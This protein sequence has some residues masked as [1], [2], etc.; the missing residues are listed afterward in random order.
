[1]ANPISPKLADTV[2]HVTDEHK[3]EKLLQ[4]LNTLFEKSMANLQIMT[5]EGAVRVFLNIKPGEQINK[6]LIPNKI[7]F[8]VKK[9]GLIEFYNELH[10]PM[11]LGGFCNEVTVDGPN[12]RFIRNGVSFDFSRPLEGTIS[13]DEL[14]KQLQ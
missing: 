2:Q 13:S 7:Y 5:R 11:L 1:M 9:E 8:D 12:Y 3:R 14:F 4:L 6:V 10:S